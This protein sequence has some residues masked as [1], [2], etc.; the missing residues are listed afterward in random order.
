MGRILAMPKY[1]HLAEIEADAPWLQWSWPK[2]ARGLTLDCT[3]DEARDLARSIWRDILA[4]FTSPVVNI[5]GDE[6]WDMGKGKNR[7]R[8]TD[9]AMGEAYVGHVRGIQDYCI[10][11]GRTTQMWGDIIRKHPDKWGRLDP[12]T[13]VLHWGYDDDA[14]YDGTKALVDAG[15]QTFVCPGTSGWK[16]IMP[17]V[18]LAE[19][20]I[21]RFA[22]TGLA[23]GA[24]G[25]INTDWGD[26][27]HF[28][29]PACS[30]HGIALGAAKGWTADHPIGEDFDRRFAMHVLDGADPIGVAH[31]RAATAIA[32]QCETWR[33]LWMPEAEVRDDPTLPSVEALREARSAAES[34]LQWCAKQEGLQISSHRDFSELG[35]A[36]NF[37]ALACHRLEW[38]HQ[39]TSANAPTSTNAGTSANAGTSTN[40]DDWADRLDNLA[41][42]YADLWLAN[43][44]PLR[45][46]DVMHV[47]RERSAEARRG[48]V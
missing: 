5:C 27:G 24:T 31:L 20:N 15:V 32:D 25:L 23:H 37:H 19:R 10:K 46:D 6:P 14:D 28:A 44:K 7:E 42:Q 45:L 3:S 48:A 22:R 1:R 2:R 4:A 12:R 38:L 9:A 8:I 43:H 29:P 41:K 17:A 30:L 26:H 18:G 36:A 39:G 47:L 11:A 35:L 13:I 40:A 34:L 33:L 21:D 16:R